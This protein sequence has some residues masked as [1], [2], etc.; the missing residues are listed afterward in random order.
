[1]KGCVEGLRLLEEVLRWG[2][3]SFGWDALRERKKRNIPFEW[4]YVFPNSCFIPLQKERKNNTLPKIEFS[5]PQSN[6][7][8]LGRMGSKFFLELQHWCLICERQGTLNSVVHL[9][10]MIYVTPGLVFRVRF[11]G[12]IEYRIDF[13]KSV[14]LNIGI[15]A[16]IHVSWSLFMF[17]NCFWLIFLWDTAVGWSGIKKILTPVPFPLVFWF[18][19][20]Q[21]DLYL[22]TNYYGCGYFLDGFIVLNV[23]Y[24]NANVCYSLFTSP[25]LYDNNVNVWHTRLGILANNVWID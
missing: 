13:R 23:D 16:V 22:D 3:A 14:F 6:I 9:W 17:M 2:V 18:S 20:H 7:T 5:P 21:T 10:S 11:R 12:S 1:M 4:T 24:D 8:L 15:R 19:V 25:N